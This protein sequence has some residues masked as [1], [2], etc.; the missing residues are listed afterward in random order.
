MSKILEA[1]KSSFLKKKT[2]NS[3]LALATV[4][5][6]SWSRARMSESYITKEK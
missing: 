1:I 2:N 3:G 5:F 4:G 6:S